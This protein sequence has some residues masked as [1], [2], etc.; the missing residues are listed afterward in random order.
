MH[1]KLLYAEAINSESE[2]NSD[3]FK[4]TIHVYA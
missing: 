3:V 1:L 2:L 4:I